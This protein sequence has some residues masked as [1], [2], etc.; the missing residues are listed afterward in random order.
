[1][2]IGKRVV[3]LWSQVNGNWYQI[4]LPAPQTREYAERYIAD[5]EPAHVREGIMIVE[6]EVVDAASA[7]RRDTQRCPAP[8]ESEAAE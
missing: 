1:M 4:H 3:Q 2:N 7:V 8:V 5:L 6:L